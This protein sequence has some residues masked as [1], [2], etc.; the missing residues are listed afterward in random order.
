MGEGV[1]LGRF[2]FRDY[3]NG[4]CFPLPCDS[5]LALIPGEDC[6]EDAF[7]GSMRLYDWREGQLVK[8]VSLVH[9]G[10]NWLDPNG[11]QEGL[12]EDTQT[13]YSVRR[14]WDDATV[15]LHL[16]TPVRCADS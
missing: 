4:Q 15:I 10:P 14:E 13:F 7:H 6:S 3:F 2:D 12:L 5:E 8:H 11:H 16:C 9:P 1:E